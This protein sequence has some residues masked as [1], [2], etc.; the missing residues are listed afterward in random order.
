[1]ETSS[2]G[3]VIA[4]VDS[5]QRMGA[6]ISVRELARS[7]GGRAVPI[8][9]ASRPRV[10]TAQE[11][12]R[13]NRPIVYL[14]ANIHGGEVEG[15]EATLALLRDWSFGRQPNVLDSLVVIVVPIYNADGNERLAVQARNRAEQNGPALI[16]ERANGMGLDL[17]R[18]Y[19]KAEAPETRGSLAAFN[20]WDPDVFIDLH[21]TDGSSHGSAL[22]YSPSLHP[23]APL[24]AY[25]ADTLLPELRRRMRD[26]HGL[27]TV[28]HGNFTTNGD[29][30]LTA[31]A[32]SGWVAYDHGQRFATNYYGLRGKISIL[33]EAFSHDPFERRVASTRAF[34]QEALSLFAE[35]RDLTRARV[36]RGREGS[37][38]TVTN[39]GPVA[40][41]A[42]V[43][44]ATVLRATVLRAP[45]LEGYVMD[46]SWAGAA[47]L[48]RLHGVT[49][50]ALE[51]PMMASVQVFTID[52]LT[53]A[54]Q[55]FQGHR[56]ASVTG[57]WKEATRL[58]PAGSFHV[59]A[60]TPHDLLAME[61]LEPESDDGLLTWNL[62][63][64]VLGRG[65][66]APVARLTAPLRL[67][68]PGRSAAPSR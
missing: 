55:P 29:E 33:G 65:K 42:T 45:S 46:V 18:D 21:T 64:A 2:H 61:L 20:S 44:R 43:L 17:D 7:A 53:I 40:V 60:A 32:K 8:I 67:Y 11:A 23:A 50:T 10:T 16:G 26:R 66:E 38:F 19:V 52:S 68:S 12:R 62:F 63:D 41:R 36:E 37:S 56:E 30:S 35:Q 4:F 59:R 6:P 28:P 13:L 3:D 49:V 1:M 47:R 34:V 15:K 31:A 24:G 25:T 54:A 27:E 48:L 58:L 51:R 57:T 5:L 9:V 14:Q 22:T 39:T